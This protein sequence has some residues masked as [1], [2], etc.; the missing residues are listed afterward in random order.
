LKARALAFQLGMPRSSVYRFLNTLL[1]RRFIQVDAT[2]SRFTL[3]PGF[4]ELVAACPDWRSLCRAGFPIMSELSAVLGETALLTVRSGNCPV[5]VER[6]EA[7][8]GT[9]PSSVPAETLSPHPTASAMV[10]LAYLPEKELQELFG[11]S[12]H[13]PMARTAALHQPLL[14]ELSQIRK[15]GYAVRAGATA[16]SVT[17]VGAPVRD[18]GEVVACLSVAGPAMRLSG[19]KLARAITLVKDHADQISKAI[20][21]HKHKSVRTRVIAE[22]PVFGDGAVKLRSDP[23]SVNEDP[24]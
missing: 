22:S 11:E 2:T 13:R 21:R 23:V 7:K 18:S 16:S 1:A 24:N 15:S 10:L 17:M 4:L 3:G 5:C 19:R 12:P 14:R 9:R 8:P 20:D 6:V